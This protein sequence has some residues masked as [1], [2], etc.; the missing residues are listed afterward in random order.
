MSRKRSLPG[1][2][3]FIHRQLQILGRIELPVSMLSVRIEV[4]HV[5]DGLGKLATV[6]AG[7]LWNT[8][9]EIQKN[10][11]DGHA[12]FHIGFLQFANGAS[13]SWLGFY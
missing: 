8:I 6:N 12:V 5:A 11:V 10:F 13:W 2:T 4:D 1:V 3:S 9:G 7:A